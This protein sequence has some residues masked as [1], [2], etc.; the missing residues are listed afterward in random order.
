MS[1]KLSPV[2]PWIL[3]ITNTTGYLPSIPIPLTSVTIFKIFSNPD[4]LPAKSLHA[5]PIQNRVE[6][7]ALASR[8]ASNTGSISINLEALV[9]VL[10][11]EDWEQYLQSSLHP[12]AICQ[13]HSTRRP[14]L[15]VH[16]GTQLDTRR[17]MMHSVDIRLSSAM[18]MPE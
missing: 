5:A 11:E 3:P 13:L 7:F 6:P 10:Y 18:A 17:V 16:Q 12:P 9:G 1:C 4:F 8:A 14:T 15:D 2:S